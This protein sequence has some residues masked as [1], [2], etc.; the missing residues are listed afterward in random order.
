MKITL[1]IE[2]TSFEN[3]NEAGM[4]I[5]TFIEQHDRSTQSNTVKAEEPKEEKTTP[6]IPKEEKAPE[7]PK[8]TRTKKPKAE[9]K[10]VAITL[11]DLKESAKNAVSRSSREDVKKTI[12]EFADKLAEVAEADYGKLYKK[13][14]ELGA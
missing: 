1:E 10:D 11:A 9:P 14:Q 12:A 6:T 4:L 13:L 7:E 8:K 2:T 5:D 3:L